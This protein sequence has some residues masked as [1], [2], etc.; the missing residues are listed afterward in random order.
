[1]PGDNGQGAVH[2]FGE[3]KRG[4]LMRKRHRP[5]GEQEVGA[6]AA[7][8]REA[9]GWS[10]AKKKL[11]LSCLL[12]FAKPVCELDRTKLFSSRI[13][14]NQKAGPGSPV[15]SRNETLLREEDLL[16][17]RGVL[18]N[19]LHIG[20]DERTPFGAFASPADSVKN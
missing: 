2:L 11:L 17:N 18:A 5:K 6:F 20:T 15:Q 16:L 8:L 1:M 9:I 3:D 12:Q 10:Y 13:E 4:H 14:K 19:P 7:G